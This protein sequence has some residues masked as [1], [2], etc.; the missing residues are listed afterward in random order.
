LQLKKIADGNYAFVPLP[1]VHCTYTPFTD[2]N[3]SV[4][5]ATHWRVLVYDELHSSIIGELQ[6][7]GLAVTFSPQLTPAEA[8]AQ[9]PAFEIIIGRTKL[10]LTKELISTAPNLKLIVRAGAGLDDI[11]LDY[12]QEKG[13]AVMNAPEGN[14]NAVA[15]HAMGL[16]LSLLHN[17]VKGNN[18]VGQLQWNREPNRGFE[19]EGKTLGIIG[20]GNN[21]TSLAKKALA[22]D[23]KV[24]AFDKYLENSPL[25]EVPLV[26]LETL[27]EEAD[28]L[29]LH[30]PLTAE[31]KGMVDAEFIN[32]FKK[33]IYLINVARGKIVSLNAVFEALEQ[34]KLLGAGLDV[35]EN[36]NITNY[37]PAERQLLNQL[38]SLPNTI[39]TPHIAGLTQESY[40]KIN[41]I[42]VQKV[43]SFLHN[44]GV[45]H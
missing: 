6:D 18:E 28:I 26:S 24:M 27:T 10:P 1:L 21:G 7:L 30:I 34:G 3:N 29:S 41:Q 11:D 43:R 4:A 42:I 35:L 20:L 5:L 37:L 40:L 14:R 17:I 16:I 19:L 9:I 2:S 36:E 38:I 25:P 23:C 12:A 22:F 33:P 31:T 15:E 13:I 45:Q 32:S 39:I 44:F 8:A